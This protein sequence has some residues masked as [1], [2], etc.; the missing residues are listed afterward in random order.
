MDRVHGCLDAVWR[1]VNV[2]IGISAITIGTYTR[3]GGRGRPLRR[4][5]VYSQDI[6]EEKRER[7]VASWKAAGI[8]RVS[9][10]SCFVVSWIVPGLHADSQGCSAT[11][12]GGEAHPTEPCNLQE[13]AVDIS[14]NSIGRPLADSEE[15]R[16]G[17][18]GGGCRC[19]INTESDL[20]CH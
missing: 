17:G 13:R 10:V 6:W 18:G 19:K 16:G 12:A 9:T 14:G 5:L 1:R 7:G 4:S 2:A 20:G 3:E 15:R 11:E 8:S